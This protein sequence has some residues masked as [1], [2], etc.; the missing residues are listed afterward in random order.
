MN[1]V[2]GRGRKEMQIEAVKMNYAQFIIGNNIIFRWKE[3]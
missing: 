1:D 3:R 2:I